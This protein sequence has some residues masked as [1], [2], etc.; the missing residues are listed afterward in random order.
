V[1]EEYS[2]S[3]SPMLAGAGRRSWAETSGASIVAKAVR[4]RD[5]ISAAA[6][7]DVTTEGGKCAIPGVTVRRVPS[8]A[9]S[10]AMIAI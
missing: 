10:L 9:P 6:S 5:F 1:R 2:N 3:E 4:Y 8:G 7:R